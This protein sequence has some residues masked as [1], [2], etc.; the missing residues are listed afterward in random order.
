[1][2]AGRALRGG[3]A[4][5]PR[6]KRFDGRAET[7]ARNLDSDK[8]IRKQRHI[9]TMSTLGGMINAVIE[10]GVQSVDV[11]VDPEAYTP[12]GYKDA[13]RSPM[14]RESMRA[15]RGALDKRG[16]WEI[17]R[18]PFGVKLI[19][20]RYV[21][22]LK[23]DWTGKVVKWK[24][25]LV[26]LGCNQVEGLDYGE[27][28]APVAK[29]TTF[30]LMVALAKVLK[31]HLHQLDVDSAFLYADLDEDIW[32]EPTPDMDIESGY[33]LKLRKSLYGLKQAPRNWFQ[34]IKEFIIGLGFK[35]TVL[36]NCLYVLKCDKEI[37]LL[38]LYVDDIIIAG[39]NL[40]SIQNLKKKFTESFDI[41]DLG[42]LNH[43]LGMKITRTYESIKIDQSTYAKDVVTRFE[44]LLSSNLDKT[45]TTPMDRDIK[46]TKTD[47]EDMTEEQ[48]RFAA[49]FPYQNAIGALLYLSINTRPDLSYSVGVLARHCIN[50]SFKACQ[51]VLRVLTFLRSTPD[52][53]IE[54]KNSEL[55]LHAY[56][57][58]DWAGDHDSRRSTTGYVV[59]AAGGP[60]AWQSKLQTTVAA[61]TMEAEYMAAFNAI[62]ECV[63]VKGVMSEIG[64]SYD[65]PI[66]L[67]MD[68]QSAICLANN[69]M[70]HKRSKHID[71]KYHWIREKV[72]DE[73]GIVRL[74]HVSSGEMVADILTKALATD[75]FEKHTISITGNVDYDTSEL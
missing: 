59:F 71:I 4:G 68:S 70:Y 6:K 46:I 42:E 66:T 10:Q 43:Y 2:D 20:S 62:Q 19:R 7:N 48:A 52:M 50:P 9:T 33:C 35:Q 36:D 34:H 5:E 21:Y 45:Y 27:T 18:K 39:S 54:F 32:M 41:K 61:S 73:D 63:W 23:K 75:A 40:D 30:R 60:I 65:S 38:S 49:R 3:T 56:S 55:D 22:K 69:P 24:S 31:L 57:D 64:F 67:F 51:A 26:I 14:W 1:M 53:G 16:C 37:F 58:A 12:T 25:R 44:H 15:E 11:E 74:L 28:F 29:A 72:G 8:R 17:V 13:A 47:L